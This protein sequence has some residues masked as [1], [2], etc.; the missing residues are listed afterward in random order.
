MPLKPAN[1]PTN[2]KESVYIDKFWDIAREL[3]KL[4]NMR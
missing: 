4:W 3:K 1:Q 2:Q